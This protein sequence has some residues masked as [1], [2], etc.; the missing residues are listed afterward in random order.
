MWAAVYEWF[1]HWQTLIAGLLALLAGV[2]TVWGTL[3]AA[4]RQVKAAQRQTEAMR[5][6]ERLRITWEGYAFHAMLEAA[7]SAVI[8]DVAAARKLPTPPT[9]E[10][11]SPQAYEMRQRV[12]RAG[13]AGLRGAF[14]RFAGPLTEFF[15]LDKE[16]D[17]Y[18]SQW[19]LRWSSTNAGANQKL[20]LNSGLLEQ[21]GSIE[22]QAIALCG[23]KSPGGGP[24]WP[25]KVA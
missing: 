15:R 7:M 22:Q 19:I 17:D 4:N 25:R 3:I 13:F 2:G 14:L 5:D 16:I 21:L 6:Q 9:R 23:T 8:E 1:D 18:S 24:G 12:K 11:H 20:G 10:A